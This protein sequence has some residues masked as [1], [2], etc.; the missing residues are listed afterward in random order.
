M[1]EWGR[2]ECPY[3]GCE[4]EP[5]DPDTIWVTMCGVES[6]IVLLGPIENGHRWAIPHQTEDVDI[7]IAMALS[8]P[9][10]RMTHTKGRS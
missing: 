7:L 4:N 5:S 10:R 9:P 1:S 2:W 8:S 3:D 6:H